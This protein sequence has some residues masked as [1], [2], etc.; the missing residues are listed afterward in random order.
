M[1]LVAGEPERVFAEQKVG[2]D[3][4]DV[5]MAATLRFPGD[6]LGHFDCGMDMPS[7]MGLEVVGAAGTLLLTD[8]WHGRA[9]RIELR[10]ADGSVEDVEVEQADPYA[11]QLRDFAGA[12]AGD[13][14]ALLGREDAVGQARAIA[15]LHASAASGEA[16]AP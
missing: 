9:P 5:R 10:R 11:M 13:H 1:R 2:G 8:P 16:V 12:A 15:A 4:V 14:P 7:S 3:G 6:V